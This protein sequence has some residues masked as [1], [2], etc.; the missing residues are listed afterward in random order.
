MGVADP[1]LDYRLIRK[2]TVPEVICGEGS[3]LL[4]G[5]YCRNLGLKRVLLVSDRGVLSAGWADEIRAK[6]ESREVASVSFFDVTENPKD[7]EVA[8]GAELYRESECEALVAVGGGSVIDCA[9][10]I[11]V[12]V[13][14][15]GPIGE[16]EGIDRIRRAMPP[17]VC[18][19]TTAGSSADVSQFAIIN[20]TSRK[21]K[22]AVISKALVPDV[23]LLDPTP[24]TTMNRE[25]TTATGMDALSHAFEAFVSNGSSF[26]TDELALKAVERLGSS[27]REAVWN[28]TKLSARTETMEGSMVAGFAF[29]NASLGAVHALA[30]AIGGLAGIPHGI[31]NA[32]LL[33]QVAR[34]N[35]PSAREKYDRLSLVLRESLALPPKGSDEALEGLLEALD[36]LA[37]DCGLE[38]SLFQRGLEESAIPEMAANAAADPCMLTN[39]RQLDLRDLEEIIRHAG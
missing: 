32:V 28:P 24:L 7:R 30:H 31:C 26:L 34:V 18:I 14:N 5:D 6:L 4:A 39:P 22:F 25:L 13:T 2:F 27:L 16:F 11:G 33:K 1:E 21:L 17:L 15:H 3:R 19:P 8:A 12:V 9:K 35:Y 38:L 29:S 37:A 20:D 36:I 23:S 10:G